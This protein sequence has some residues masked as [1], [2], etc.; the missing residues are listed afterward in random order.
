M[1]DFQTE[2]AL[3]FAPMRVRFG[4]RAV[5]ADAV[6]SLGGG[7]TTGLGKAI[8]LQTDLPQIVVPTTCAGSE[9]MAILGQTDGG[10]KTTITDPRVQPEGIIH[11]PA[12]LA[13]LPIALTV[14]SGRNAIAHAAEALHVR[15]RNPVSTALAVAA[16]ACVGSSGHEPA[17]QTVP[18]ALR[19]HYLPGPLTYHI[20]D[21]HVC[22]GSGGNPCFRNR[23]TMDVNAGLFPCDFRGGA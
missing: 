14:T 10:H 23:Q 20:P 13:T 9:A 6:V 1:T 2:F 16:R 5:K 3:R 17:P 19:H 4:V 12:L 7:S 18:C 21:R 8:A 15:D 11:D 22:Q